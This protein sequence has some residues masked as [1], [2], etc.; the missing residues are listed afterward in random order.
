[1]STLLLWATISI[2]LSFLCSI[3]EAVLLS[4]TPTF[5]SIKKREGKI[6]ASVLEALKKDIDKPLI[7]ILT[8][9]T[10]AHTV[11]AMMVGIEAKKIAL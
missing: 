7:A 2:F 8:I 10:I 5:I 9:N 3:L 6:Y 11:G 1:M 4:D